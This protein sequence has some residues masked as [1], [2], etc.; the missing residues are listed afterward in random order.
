MDQSLVPPTAHACR[1]SQPNAD[2]MVLLSQNLESTGQFLAHLLRLDVDG[3]VPLAIETLAG[4]TISWLNETPR[5][6]EEQVGELLKYGRKFQRI[7]VETSGADA[8]AGLEVRHACACGP[9]FVRGFGLGRPTKSRNRNRNLSKVPEG[10]EEQDLAVA[11]HIALAG[12]DDTMD[13]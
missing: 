9:D 10:Y 13:M 4:D 3:P 5:R 8:L 2:A 6:R 11:S 1:P 7:V 12:A